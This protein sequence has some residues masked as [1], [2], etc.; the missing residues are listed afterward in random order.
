M[1]EPTPIKID[2]DSVSENTASQIQEALGIKGEQTQQNPKGLENSEGINAFEPEPLK[3]DSFLNALIE[4]NQNKAPAQETNQAEDDV[5]A[6]QQLIAEGADPTQLLEETAAGEGEPTD[7]GGIYIPTI[8]RTGEEVLADAGFD[9]TT[10]ESQELVEEEVLITEPVVIEPP[11]I[12]V[13]ND[14]EIS[15]VD[16]LVVDEDG[17]P[18]AVTDASPLRTGETDSTESATATGNF[19]IDAPDGVGSVTIEGT[20]I[21]NNGVLVS[22]APSFTTGLGNTFTVTAYDAATGE[23]TYQYTLDDNE[24]HKETDDPNT[25]PIETAF[26]DDSVSETFAVV[27]TDTDGDTANSSITVKIVDD[28]PVA[29]TTV[30]LTGTVDEDGVTGGIAGGTGDVTGENTVASG[31][32][33]TLFNSGADAPLN[34]ALATDTVTTLV[35]LNLTSAN[36]ALTYAVIGDTVTATANSGTIFTFKLTSA[37]AYTF[38]LEDQLDHAS[39]SDEN[40]LPINLSG[41]ITAKDADGDSVTAAASGL[42]ITVDDD[43][44]TASTT[45]LLTGTVDEDGVTGGI[46]GGTGDVTG[47]NTVASGSV[48]TLFNSGADAPLNYALA[49]DTVTTL[50]ALNLTSANA[51]L[52]YAVI[53]DTV[54]ATANSGTIFTFKLTSAGAYTFTLEDQLD[55]ASGSDENDL[56]INLS[57]IITAKD[58]DGDSVTAAASGLIITV[59]DDTPTAADPENAFLANEVG[60]TLTGSLNSFYGADD[61]GTSHFAMTDES[62]VFA[63]DGTT[64]VTVAGVNI[65]YY[66]DPNN[67]SHVVASLADP[68]TFDSANVFDGSLSQNDSWVFEVTLDV[69][70]DEYTVLMYQSV[71][72]PFVNVSVGAATREASGP[73]QWIILQN[74]ATEN[75]VEL[76][77]YEASDQT[78]YNSWLAS[79]TDVAATPFKDMNGSLAGWGVNNNNHDQF[80]IVHIE[81][82]DGNNATDDSDAPTTSGVTDLPLVNGVTLDFYTNYSTGNIIDIKVHYQNGTSSYE[83]F[84]VGTSEGNSGD[85]YYF[86]G[87]LLIIDGGLLAL[88]YLEAGVASGSGKFNITDVSRSLKTGAVDIDLDIETI[89]D[90]G[91]VASSS[92]D[93]QVSGADLGTTFIGTTEGDVLSGGSGN[94]ILIG[95]LADDT[96]SG[97]SGNDT[98][99]WQTGGTGTDTIMDWGIGTDILDLSELL[100]NENNGILDAYLD[101]SYAASNTTLTIDVD[102]SGSGTDEQK[103]IFD[104]VDLTSN[105]TLSDP[106]IITNLLTNNQLITD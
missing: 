57:G 5:E 3:T 59:D 78:A 102:G 51:A 100:L 26:E 58:A 94:D 38:T 91:D 101:F 34:Y 79:G 37:G 25:T 22:A 30:L 86:N 1:A 66:I 19:V 90:D 103:I 63:D 28:I 27:L 80:E 96:L 12:S 83:Q 97:G 44:P 106:T 89:D 76:T 2:P 4:N 74:S 13:D 46:A 29:S 93:I 9:T 53:G 52:T 72:A 75:L 17:L 43:T 56:P 31:S 50:V 104:N 15:G 81:F 42:I 99:K 85:E 7:G 55:H 40:D 23:V 87:T 8:E 68:T 35:A 60:S 10:T 61:K 65:Y 54:T 92:I 39:G 21:I 18:G 11:T 14:V 84:V 62:Q 88:D 95:G 48:A 73:T 71:D 82:G 64:P 33:A 70:P 36:A 24:I 45:V 20:Q 67:S 47:E 105:S 69:A 41:I 77:S 98:F 49:T 16:D 32:V 6:L